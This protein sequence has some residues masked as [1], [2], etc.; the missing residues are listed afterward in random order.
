MHLNS[1]FAQ[2]ATNISNSL[3]GLVKILISNFTVNKSPS[4]FISVTGTSQNNSTEEI[5]HFLVNVTSYDINNDVER[6]IS[7]IVSGPFTI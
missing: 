4:G 2:P 7:R 6:E 3:P 1:S 5:D